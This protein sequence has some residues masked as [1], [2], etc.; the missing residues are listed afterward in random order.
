DL[1]GGQRG[2]GALLPPLFGRPHADVVPV[3]RPRAADGAGGLLHRVRRRHGAPA[4][5]ANQEPAKERVV[6]AGAIWPVAAAP[7]IAGERGLHVPPGGLVDDGLVLAGVPL[8]A[9]G[10]LPG[11]GG[12]GQNPP[13]DRLV[14]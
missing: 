10:H 5:L 9:I 8:V 14:D 1:A 6:A 7:A 2:A 11:V 4:R 12:A 3:S 13:E